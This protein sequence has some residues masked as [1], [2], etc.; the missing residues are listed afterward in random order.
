M[1]EAL[2]L[3]TPTAANLQPPVSVP[4]LEH[5]HQHLAPATLVTEDTGDD[6]DGEI[7]C[8]C[9]FTGDDGA[10]VQCDKCLRWQ[11]ISCYYPP[12][13]EVPG[14]DQKHYCADC[15]DQPDLDARKA[16]DRQRRA[17]EQRNGTNGIKR[18]AAKAPKKKTKDSPSL[19]AQVNGWSDRHTHLHNHDRKSASPRDQPPPAKKPKTSHRSS[20]SVSQSLGRKR[21]STVNAYT[22]RSPS[23]SPELNT[24]TFIPLYSD[25]FLHLFQPQSPRIETETNLMSNIAVTG[26]LSDWLTDPEAV[27]KAT[28]GLTQ[29]DVFKR[30]DGQV[31]DIPGR[32]PVNVEWIEDPRFAADGLTPRWA[33][34][35]VEEQIQ[36]GTFIGELRG[37]IGLKD[38]YVSD[39]EN[40]WA[41][42]HHPEPFV[43][44]HPQ[45]P[46]CIDARQEGSSFRFVRRSCQPNA[47]LQTIITEQ[48]EYHF[49][50]MAKREIMPGEE[51][52]VAWQ[53]PDT[54][55][56][57][58]N[59]SL[60]TSNNFQPKV[61]DYISTW[62]SNVLANCGPCACNGQS[63]CLMAHYD[64]RGLSPPLAPSK[65][66]KRKKKLP[67]LDT[68]ST[69]RSRSASE[70]RKTDHDEEGTDSRSVSGSHESA[71]RDITPNTHYSGN[72]TSAALPELSEREKKKL[73]R[74]EEM[75]RRQE[76]ES[77]RQK[78]KRHS[79][80]STLTPS[81]VSSSVRFTLEEISHRLGANGIQQKTNGISSR[82]ADASTSS[83]PQLA[84]R[85]SSGKR[86]AG[87][88]KTSRKESAIPLRSS[89]V[90]YVDACV[91]C[92]LEP[93]EPIQPV[94]VRPYK[95]YVSVSQ[96]LLKRCFSSNFKKSLSPQQPS[97]PAE[98]TSDVM[99]VDVK[100]PLPN[101][102]STLTSTPSLSAPV[103]VQSIPQPPL[104][105]P[106]VSH[107]ID[108]PMA[109]VEA[110]MTVKNESPL[111]AKQATP[112]SPPRSSPPASEARSSISHPAADGPPV[113]SLQSD[114]SPAREVSPTAPAPAPA[115]AETQTRPPVMHLDM[116]PPPAGFGG[117][118]SAT[119]GTPSFTL[120][121]SP[122]AVTPGPASA[123]LTAPMF[124]PNVNTA[125]SPSPARK[126][127]SLSDYT[128]RSKARESLGGE[129]SNP[130]AL[131]KEIKEE[132]VVSPISAAGDRTE[133]KDAE[134]AE[135]GEDGGDEL[136]AENKAQVEQGEDTPAQQSQEEG[137][138]GSQDA[139]DVVAD[140]SVQRPPVANM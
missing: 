47:E 39:A 90:S 139:K 33:R 19:T 26:H 24:T 5:F 93:A 91:Q 44:F 79:G 61:R 135:D 36:Q 98:P 120:T 131:A 123:P 69:N 4:T 53:V 129:T 114:A 68:G 31:E 66:I 81:G 41:L 84:P 72:G 8:I 108:V 111:A 10:T 25:E 74:E 132:A 105:V 127:M 67:T 87:A 16:T 20:N 100:A 64:R 43:F 89:A 99:D 22:A 101:P 71:S 48:T 40:R 17:L 92:D 86:K 14:T 76:E 63:N 109:D 140:E 38:D 96:R 21:G 126:K 29:A 103:D 112:I 23:K 60:A 88:G 130:S 58:I 117:P 122:T 2:S 119:A 59:S 28:G 13:K 35:V 115:S 94:P 106:P 3:A 37:R 65:P 134:D 1:T 82:Y 85:S 50:F 57:R 128:K 15:V 51:V 49:C 12:P 78:K 136:V 102:T 6:D 113:P 118:A 110:D 55:R 42:L 83:R 95:R 80:G 46:I 104:E 62:I 27:S 133:E 116:P 70:V 45:L 124:S 107:D 97:P 34:L 138:E 7:A 125:V 11:H 121:Q 73:M 75:F 137:P 77:G 9:A 18:S 32:P 52:T 30:W 56:E 54:I